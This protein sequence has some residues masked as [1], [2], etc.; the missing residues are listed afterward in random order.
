MHYKE[1][2]RRCRERLASVPIPNPF[3]LPALLDGLARQRRKTITLFP[4]PA[5]TSANLPC[6][7]WL[8][9]DHADYVFVD[10]NTTPLHRD[11][12]VCHEIGHII[13]NHGGNSVLSPELAA[14]L[15]PSLNPSMVTRVLGRGGY[16]DA[17][18]QEAE[19]IATLILRR[20]GRGSLHTS[21]TRRCA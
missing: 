3:D 15:L 10:A 20:G 13:C 2:Q 5:A 16:S 1:L 8:S 6:G 7:I 17:D 11:H 12:I 18:E 4:L 14:A 9:T 19:M 21:A